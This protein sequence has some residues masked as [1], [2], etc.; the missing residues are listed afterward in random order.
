MIVKI[1]NHNISSTTNY[2]KKEDKIFKK[3]AL[4]IMKWPRQSSRTPLTS[5]CPKFR[6]SDVLVS[7][8][9]LHARRTRIEHTRFRRPAQRTTARPLCSAIHNC[10][11]KKTISTQ[12]H[13]TKNSAVIIYTQNLV[14]IPSDAEICSTNLGS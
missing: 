3:R 11:S 14:R 8:R 13:L 9:I 10:I 6:S 7:R 5:D 12:M 2:F 1:K 4:R